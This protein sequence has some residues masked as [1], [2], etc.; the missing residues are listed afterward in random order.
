MQTADT[1]YGRWIDPDG[2][3][4][5]AEVAEGE[6]PCDLLSRSNLGRATTAPLY[7]TTPRKPTQT[8]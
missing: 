4:N 3:R 2:Y 7:A 5:P 1:Y 8:R 6:L